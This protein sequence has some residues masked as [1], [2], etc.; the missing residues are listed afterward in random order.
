[1]RDGALDMYTGH[2]PVPPSELR[3]A[4]LPSTSEAHSSMLFPRMP[5][6]EAT[7]AWTSGETR[8][9]NPPGDGSRAGRPCCSPAAMRR[10]S[11]SRKASSRESGG[12]N[13]Q[14]GS[15][16][17]SENRDRARLERR[18]SDGGVTTDR[19]RTWRTAH[20]THSPNGI[21]GSIVPQ[22]SRE[23][24]LSPMSATTRS[25]RASYGSPRVP[26]GEAEAVGSHGA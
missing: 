15:D 3:D 13:H 1:M 18:E 23:I 25:G 19:S 26:L 11:D 10:G 20:D 16:S 9:T 14:G 21:L 17:F 6:A 8:S 22:D 24:C 4:A 12:G 2:R 7:A 5:A